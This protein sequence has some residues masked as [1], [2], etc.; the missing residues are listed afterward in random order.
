MNNI[1][2]L[3]WSHAQ[4]CFIAVSEITKRKG[5]STLVN[6]KGAVRK[7]LYQALVVGLSFFSFSSFGYEAHGTAGEGAIAI[8]GGDKQPATSTGY[9]STSVGPNS[10]AEGRLASAFG[11]NAKAIGDESIAVGASAYAEGGQSLSIGWKAAAFKSSSTAIGTSA[12]AYNEFSTAIGFSA[13]ASDNNALAIG[14]LSSAEKTSAIA[15]GANAKAQ[16]VHSITIGNNAIS[17]VENGVAIGTGSVANTQAGQQPYIVSKASEEDKNRVL[18]T[19]G[20]GGG[21]SFGRN[22]EAGGEVIYRQLTNVAAGYYDTDAVNVAQLKS[23]ESLISKDGNFETLVVGKGADNSLTFA[24]KEGLTLSDK[25]GNKLDLTATGIV[26]HDADG[27]EVEAKLVT[28]A[29]D[30]GTPKTGTRFA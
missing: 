18:Q 9:Y 23:V 1:Y 22:K 11:D 10:K 3:V 24:G 14:T 5:K 16:A 19:K 6:D 13:K 15:I 28:L 20:T 2:R 29:A 21:V 26:A 17:N 30:A 7:P 8:G 27:K 4:S 25:S 12:M